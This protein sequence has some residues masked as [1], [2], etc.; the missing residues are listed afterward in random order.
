MTV[1]VSACLIAL[2]FI[3]PYLAGNVYSL[4]F[5]KKTMGIISTYVSGMAIIY[6]S[7]FVL[8]LAIIK[9]RF[10]FTDVTKIYPILFGVFIVLG[11]LC[12]VWKL[13]KEKSVLW[14]VVWSKKTI[15]IYAI[16]VLQGILYIFL[17]NPYF[18]NNALL[19]TTK[20]TME[21][22]TI[23]EYNA[24]TGGEAVAGFPLSNKLM[25]LPMLY[26]YICSTFS[27]SPVV[28]FNFIVPVVTFV[29]FYLVMNLWVQKL[30]EKHKVDGTMLLLFLVWIV[31]VGDS[32]SH[33]TAFRILH[34][35][36]M[37]EAIFFGVLFTYALYAIRNKCY[38]ISVV[39][40][41][42]FPGLIKYDAVFDFIKGF[43]GYWRE[44]ITYGGMLVIYIIALVY[45]INTHKKTS[46]H[47]LNLN[48]T[49][50][51]SFAEIWMKVMRKESVKRRKAVGG[52]LLL[53]LLLMCGNMTFISGATQW[54]SNLYGAPKAEYELLKSIAADNEE[55]DLKLMAHDE[56]LC[57]VRRLD[58]EMVPVVGYDLGGNGIEWYSYETYDERHVELWES[59]H[60]VSADMEAELMKLKEDIP[61]DYIVVKRITELV[62]IYDNPELKCVYK[63]PSYLVYSVDKK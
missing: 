41:L 10:N 8:Q 21:T 9:L 48:L 34:T 13:C 19:E 24:F 52:F 3:I 29:S 51:L 35:G 39:C 45:Y 11:S 2:F 18:E 30:G 53:G 37:G 12:F 56:L 43:G 1:L 16:I 38:F 49:I 28:L 57:W 15:W 27:I 26:A 40:L 31:Q 60:Y 55:A 36:Y 62:P 44:G 42:T 32:W 61:M 50:A 25:F 33:S 47:L 6:A 22:G 17:K 54:R 58:F 5:R 63:T 4:L 59:V 23:Y 20:V 14:D 46:L 7:L